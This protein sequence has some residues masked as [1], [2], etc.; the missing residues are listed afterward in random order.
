MPYNHL[1]H[2]DNAYEEFVS[3][4][5][6]FSTRPPTYQFLLRMCR[7]IRMFGCFSLFVDADVLTFSKCL[8]VSGRCFEHFLPLIPKEQQ[9]TSRATPLL[10]AI[11]CCDFDGASLISRNLSSTRNQSV[12]YEE[13]FLYF[14]FLLEVFFRS[15][16]EN[17]CRRLLNS[18]ERVIEEN[19]DNR[20]DV[21]RALLD[22]DA[23]AFDSALC[24]LIAQY[25]DYYSRMRVAAALPEAALISEGKIFIEGLAL[26]RLAERRG[27][28]VD[29]EY[30]MIPSLT[31]QDFSTN[32]QADEWRAY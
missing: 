21:A 30:P 14:Q 23:S 25:K 2:Q 8:Q 3:L 32:F 5:T 6:E 26:I 31:R 28:K 19:H 29:H 20:L 24:A 7:G 15:G 27:L 12:E 18:Y 9:V 10:D 4:R 13:D 17:D 1:V 11:A 16:D 22:R